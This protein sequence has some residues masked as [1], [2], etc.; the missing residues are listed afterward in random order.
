MFRK[1][2]FVTALFLTPTFAHGQAITGTVISI[3]PAQLRPM[4]QA[5]NSIL[6]PVKQTLSSDGKSVVN[7]SLPLVLSSDVY[8]KVLADKIRVET[9]ADDYD[10]LRQAAQELA[11]NKFPDEIREGQAAR[12]QGDSAKLAAMSA[13]ID[14]DPE[15]AAN[16]KK[17]SEDVQLDLFV[18]DPDVDLQW[19]KNDYFNGALINF[20]MLLTNLPQPVVPPTP[21]AQATPTPKVN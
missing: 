12:A 15:I 14:A 18:F 7:V 3:P 5:L 10:K 17:L 8:K 11:Q 21:E 16:N 1:I 13:K 20:P 19:E 2:A 4:V 6:H 9:A